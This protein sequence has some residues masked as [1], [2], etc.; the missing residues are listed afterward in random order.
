[1][2]NRGSSGRTGM[3]FGTRQQ[4]DRI[5]PEWHE[6]NGYGTGFGSERMRNRGSSGR[7]GMI[8]GTRQ[9]LD[10]IKPEW[11]GESGPHFVRR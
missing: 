6:E 2:R 5:K 8:F 3:I 4:L 10:R 9:Q 11:K 1:M 7:T